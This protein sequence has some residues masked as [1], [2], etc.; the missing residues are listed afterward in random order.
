[1]RQILVVNVCLFFRFVV[2]LLH[3]S[4]LLLF[5]FCFVF[6][7]KS[8][9]S[10]FEIPFFTLFLFFR[11]FCFCFPFLLSLVR[12][13]LLKYFVL[14][15]FIFSKGRVLY[16]FCVCFSS[17]VCVLIIKKIRYQIEKRSKKERKSK[18]KENGKSFRKSPN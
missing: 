13:T 14:R 5:G 2:I 16:N 11:S 9:I 1:M 18:K 8:I 3:L 15:Q 7:R 6:S 17:I 10:L 12:I 4:S